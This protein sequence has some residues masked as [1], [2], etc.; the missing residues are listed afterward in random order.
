[1]CEVDA[2]WRATTD[3]PAPKK[4]GLPAAAAEKEEPRFLAK[5]L[6][7]NQTSPRTAA[8]RRPAVVG[9]TVVAAAAATRYAHPIDQI[10]S[11]NS[12]HRCSGLV[13][14]A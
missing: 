3:R 9:R 6:F 1:M 10:A 4:Q 11:E 12:P 14:R 7:R 8:L 13:V 5:K 2:L